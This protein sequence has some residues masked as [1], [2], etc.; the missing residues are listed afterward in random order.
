MDECVAVTGDIPD[1]WIRDSAVQVG[2]YMPR[3]GQHPALRRV[4]EGTL[5]MQAFLITQVSPSIMGES[6][7]VAASQKLSGIGLQPH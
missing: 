3:I 1:M 6:A 7:A 5:R 2:V 4:V